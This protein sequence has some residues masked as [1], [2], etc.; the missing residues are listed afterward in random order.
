MIAVIGM[1]KAHGQ[2]CV[3]RGYPTRRLTAQPVI[4]PEMD[5]REMG[6]VTEPVGKW[7]R[8]MRVRPTL[9]SDV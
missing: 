9:L 3:D 8:G 2:K 7:V 5:H 6:F 4:M 1:R